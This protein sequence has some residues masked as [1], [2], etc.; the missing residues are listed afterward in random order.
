VVLRRF[1]NGPQGCEVSIA[2]R[3]TLPHGSG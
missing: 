2:S 3:M 1:Q